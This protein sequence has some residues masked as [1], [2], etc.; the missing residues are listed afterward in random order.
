MRERILKAARE[1]FAKQG[2]NSISMRTLASVAEM[3]PTSL[4]RFYPNKRA[5]L[6]HIWGEI[7]EQLFKACSK[8]V[9]D[10]GGPRD[11][12]IAYA[13]CF[14]EYWITHPEIYMMVY[15]EIDRP[16]EGESFF[17]DSKLMSNEL[18]HLTNL[19]NDAGVATAELELTLQ[20]LIC[21]MHGVCHS[22]VTIPEL[23]WRDA[24]SITGG[25]VESLISNTHKA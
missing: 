9:Q 11:A 4:Y 10:A 23:N 17:A 14:V 18:A 8:A 2:Y 22:L 21:L 1:L 19:L 5:I 16:V 24:S 7:F 15:G 12:L 13:N 3:S 20:K 6:V 25:L